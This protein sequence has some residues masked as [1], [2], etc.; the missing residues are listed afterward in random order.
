MY[1]N[2]VKNKHITIENLTWNFLRQEKKM[3]IDYQSHI[4]K[5]EQQNITRNLL[6]L[7]L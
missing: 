4:L 7:I 5:L 2:I 6:W 3:E 1:L